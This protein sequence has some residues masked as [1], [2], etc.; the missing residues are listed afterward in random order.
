MVSQG[1]SRYNHIGHPSKF[2]LLIA[3]EN[4]NFV[5]TEDVNFT[6]LQTSLNYSEKGGRNN[7]IMGRV[8]E[9]ITTT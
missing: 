9:R 7:A 5:I 1:K 2:E 8:I 4:F 6:T 3:E